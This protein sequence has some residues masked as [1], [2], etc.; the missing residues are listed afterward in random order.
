MPPNRRADQTSPPSGPLAQVLALAHRAGMRLPDI[1]FPL[2][3]L[4]G[5]WLAGGIDRGSGLS[6]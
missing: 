3:L 4:A 1:G 6:D 2:P 5:F